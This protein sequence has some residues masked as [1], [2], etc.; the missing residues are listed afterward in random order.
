MALTYCCSV[1]RV[2]Y[3]QRVQEVKDVSMDCSYVQ[4][5]H[6]EV[7]EPETKS[8]KYSVQLFLKLAT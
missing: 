1:K 5:E 8:A 7:S 4:Q 2:K 3:Y 6:S